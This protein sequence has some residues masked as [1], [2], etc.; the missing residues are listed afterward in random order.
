MGTVLFCMTLLPVLK[1]TREEFEPKCVEVF[2]YLDD[3]SIGTV[4]LT[5]NTED[6]F[7]PWPACVS[8]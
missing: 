7:P 5:S 8:P 3:I 2:A 6:I 4:E 1:R